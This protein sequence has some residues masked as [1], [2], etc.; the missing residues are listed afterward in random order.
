MKTKRAKRSYKEVEVIGDGPY[1]VAL[2]G[3]P[4]KT[5][6]KRPIEFPS[7]GLAEAVAAEW[8]RQGERVD[9]DEMPLTKL[10]NTAIDRILGDEH[11]VVLEIL[12]YAGT[13]LVCYRAAEPDSLVTQQG[14]FWDPILTW[15]EETLGARFFSVQGITH[16]A[17]SEETLAA[18]T[19]YL[20]KF[21]AMRLAALHNLTALTGSALI[22]LA[23]ERRALDPE[24]AWLAAHVDED[25]QMER[26]GRDEE[27]A[28]RRAWHKQ[29]FDA[30]VKFLTLLS[31]S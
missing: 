21:D 4:I 31:Q 7:S 2:D 12:N 24:R 1:R 26:W 19:R 9:P 16:Q 29:D 25:W 23:L 14:E 10:A 5:P 11:R 27:A 20:Q 15:A 3:R 28:E 13:D 22:P 6:L 8:A 17:Q 30:A 18:M